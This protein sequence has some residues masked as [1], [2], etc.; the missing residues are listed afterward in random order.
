[1]Q[2]ITFLSLAATATAAASSHLT[3]RCSPMYDPE[4]A[5]GY[6]PP[7]PC[8]QTFD[9]ACQPQ[10]KNPMT[11][12]AN[13]KMA[14][15]HELSSSCVGEIEEELAREAAGRKNNN[16]TR[17][18]GNLHLIGDGTLVISNMSDAAVARYAGLQYP[19]VGPSGPSG[20]STIAVP[21]ATTI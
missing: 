19:G 7:A 13:Y 8:W 6:L 12:I 18:Q 9:P 1:M 3:K 21:T 2:L 5:L 14:V 16:W 11:L 17:T 10:L 4:L 20:I 15:I